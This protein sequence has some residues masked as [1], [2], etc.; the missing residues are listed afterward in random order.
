MELTG[1]NK[2]QVFVEGILSLL[3][4]A[5]LVGALVLGL[6]YAQLCWSHQVRASIWARQLLYKESLCRPWREETRHLTVIG[7]CDPQK[8]GS[9]EVLVE[10]KEVLSPLGSR[11]ITVDWSVETLGSSLL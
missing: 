10:F 7:T 6:C 5:P 9:V 2:G 11:T 4:V 8:L 3:V 1:A